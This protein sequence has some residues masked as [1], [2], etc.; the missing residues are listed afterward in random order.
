M[1]IHATER[2]S[3]LVRWSVISLDT[4]P[5]S[6][7]FVFAVGHAGGIWAGTPPASGAAPLALG[8][9]VLAQML[10]FVGF[11]LGFGSIAFTLIVPRGPGM[12]TA[13]SR[14]TPVEPRCDR[15]RRAAG[16]RATGSARATGQFG[17][18]RHV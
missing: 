10:H 17:A 2:G 12:D 8:L 3:Y 11:A 16:G 1:A 6:G 4:H 14:G 18:R 5:A 9:L 13:R 15:Y 7:S